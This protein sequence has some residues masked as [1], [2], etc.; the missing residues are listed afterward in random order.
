MTAFCQ[1]AVEQKVAVVSGSAFMTHESDPTQCFRLNFST[2]TDEA[3]VKG[4]Q[5]LGQVKRQF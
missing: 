5:I 2:P 3:I 1:A 4:M